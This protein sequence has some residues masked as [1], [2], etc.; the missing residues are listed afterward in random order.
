MDPFDL[1][2]TLFPRASTVAEQLAL[3]LIFVYEAAL[4]WIVPKAFWA[5]TEEINDMV[6]MLFMLLC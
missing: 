4:G 5:V 2:C 6:W 1:D 3:V